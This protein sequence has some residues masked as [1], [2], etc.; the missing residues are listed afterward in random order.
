MSIKDI[1]AYKKL[2]VKE[3]TYLPDVGLDYPDD[4][5]IRMIKPKKITH[6]FVLDENYPYWDESFSYKLNIFLLRMKFWTLVLP[7][8]K[9]VYG[10]KVE[11]NGILKKYKKEMKNGASTICKHGFSIDVGVIIAA[12]RH[13]SWIPMLADNMMTDDHWHMK[14]TGGIPIPSTMSALKKYNEAFD[15]HH[16]KGHWFHLFPEGINWHWYKPLKPFYKGA[17]SMAYKYNMPILPLYINYRPRTGIY[18][19]FAKPEIPL[20]TISVGEPIFP[21]VTKP[22]KV[23]IDH[24]RET[25]F[26]KMLDMAGIIENPWPAVPQKDV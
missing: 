9:V 6:P 7:M 11:R 16:E 18:K 4:P 2:K 25:A 24:L 21:D 19:W 5:S 17:F 13:H 1:P 23:E 22:R 8:L 3:G 15:K 10:L 12:T 20:L 14:Y 26:E